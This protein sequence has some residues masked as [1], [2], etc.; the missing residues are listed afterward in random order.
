MNVYEY[1]I[2]KSEDPALNGRVLAFATSNEE[3]EAQLIE[4]TFNGAKFLEWSLVK[5]SKLVAVS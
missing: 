3:A 4:S 5:V 2:T 1:Q